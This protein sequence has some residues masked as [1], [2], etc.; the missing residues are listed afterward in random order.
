MPSHFADSFRT[1]LTTFTTALKLACRNNLL[2][3][4]FAISKNKI[5]FSQSL[6][7]TDVPYLWKIY[8]SCE[9]DAVTWTPALEQQL[10]A[11]TRMHMFDFA[12]V[13]A[14]MQRFSQGND[15]T[16][17]HLL[18]PDVCRVHF[19]VID[20]QERT[21]SPVARSPVRS[22]SGISTPAAPAFP[23][24]RL[25]SPPQPTGR[26]SNTAVTGRGG[27]TTAAMG[28][29]S[30]GRGVGRGY[31]RGAP[32]AISSD[33]DDGDT[34]D[35]EEEHSVRARP[36]HQSQAVSRRVPVEA[37]APQQQQQTTSIV[38]QSPR[39]GA[40]SPELA[41]AEP[42]STFNAA[43]TDNDDRD[44]DLSL[45]QRPVD[46]LIESRGKATRADASE[47]AARVRATFE[48]LASETDKP[49]DFSIFTHSLKD[50]FDEI[51]DDVRRNLPNILSQVESGQDSDGDDDTQPVDIGALKRDL[52][53][54][55]MRS[56]AMIS[57]E[58]AGRLLEEIG[59]ES[60]VLDDSG[61]PVVATASA[62][63]AAAVVTY[64]QAVTT[65]AQADLFPRAD[66]PDES[67][68][69]TNALRGIDLDRLLASLQ[70]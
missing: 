66:S 12:K 52:T 70:E 10:C 36:L 62:A 7:L 63:A 30:R 55:F 20:F 29:G 58:D 65:P 21:S 3:K 46:L 28:R 49:S 56:L 42:K 54:P 48:V 23:D 19:A 14:E 22:S 45:P 27:G 38:R 13:S 44:D 39:S 34:S 40:A 26:L 17:S 51:F 31:G 8:G 4:Y 43:T 1:I 5:H 37:S 59:D 57:A 67:P 50:R 9:M 41:S 25:T 32:A 6:P 2:Q 33:S 47:A 61:F 60:F 69:D 68:L 64:E 11:L 53:T 24:D 16:N 18:T 15:I 35:D